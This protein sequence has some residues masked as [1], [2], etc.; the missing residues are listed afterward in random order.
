MQ[1]NRN[2]IKSVRG[3]HI[4]KQ[5]LVELI[6]EMF[7]DDEVGKSGSIAQITTIEMT[8][9]TINQSIVF[10]KILNV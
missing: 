1:E 8:D 2:V 10:G 7:P 9:G 3:Q 6:N 5:G 4:T